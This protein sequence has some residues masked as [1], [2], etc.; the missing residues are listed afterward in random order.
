MPRSVAWAARGRRWYVLLRHGL[1]CLPR[2]AC[3]LGLAAR[4]AA[5]ENS[6]GCNVG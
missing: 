2:S 6:A 5:S 3:V 4:V 1:R